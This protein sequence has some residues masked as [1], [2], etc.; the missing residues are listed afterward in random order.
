MA[1][2][3]NILPDVSAQAQTHVAK[4]RLLAKVTEKGAV[5][6]YGLQRFP[7]TLY[8]DQWES[9]LANS[10]KLQAFIAANRG[11][12]KVKSDTEATVKEGMTAL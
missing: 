6:V 1:K 8:L 10:A 5:S 11:S 12:L 4:H 9:L 3:R 7:V 2:A